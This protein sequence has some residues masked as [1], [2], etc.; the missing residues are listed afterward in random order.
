[1]ISD[2]QRLVF[3]AVALFLVGAGGASGGT[4][5][6]ADDHGDPEIIDQSN[7][8]V[9]TNHVEPSTSRVRS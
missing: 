7:A 9:P 4:V 8:A 6:A 5:L 3:A 1:V 2:R